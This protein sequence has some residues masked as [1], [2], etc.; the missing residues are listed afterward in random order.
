MR[1]ILLLTLLSGCEWY[2]RQQKV[3]NCIHDSCSTVCGQ[4]TT[5]EKLPTRV[6]E[7][8]KCTKRCEEQFNS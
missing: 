7:C 3:M 8:P 1:W 4:C 5:C 2:E 6:V